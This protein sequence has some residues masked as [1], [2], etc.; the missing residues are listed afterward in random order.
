MF[1][2][3]G[4]Q[5]FATIPYTSQRVSDSPRDKEVV[6]VGLWAAIN[7]LTFRTSLTGREMTFT[8]V[9]SACRRFSRWGH[10]GVNV[11]ESIQ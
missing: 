4:Y 2:Q 1:E 5:G 3:F 6:R 11:C 10:H 9:S 8:V 7:D